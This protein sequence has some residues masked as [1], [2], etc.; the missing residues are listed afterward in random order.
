MRDSNAPLVFFPPLPCAPFYFIPVT[1]HLAH[2]LEGPP[3]SPSSTHTHR[4]CSLCAEYNSNKKQSRSYHHLHHGRAPCRSRSVP[5]L[6]FSRPQVRAPQM[7]AVCAR[8]IAYVTSGQERKGE[9]GEK[10]RR[11]HTSLSLPLFLCLSPPSLSLSLPRYFGICRYLAPSLSLR[12]KCGRG[13][14]PHSA[15]HIILRSQG[16]CVCVCLYSNTLHMQKK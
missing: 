13:F 3:P 7:R 12:V 11:L 4:L 14:K 1:G 2:T 6:R 10:K 5:G 16:A 15:S 9:N 8:E